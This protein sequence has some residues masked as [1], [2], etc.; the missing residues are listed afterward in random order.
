MIKKP[1]EYPKR[2]L[3]AVS[4]MSPQIISET[5]FALTQ[6]EE[7]FIPTEIRV[8]TTTTGKQKI[9]KGLFEDGYFAKLCADYQL[10]SIDFTADNIEVIQ[11]EDNTDLSD[12]KTV[13]ENEQAA[14]S[15]CQFVKKYTNDPDSAVH[16]SMA[17]GRKSMGFLMGYA[18]SLF[19]R[20]QDRLS[21][22][23]VTEQFESL[24]DFY[25]P[26]KDKTL[27]KDRLGNEHDASQA[28]VVLADIPFVRL[29]SGLPA[30]LI[31]R[32]KTDEQDKAFSYSN[33]V[34]SIQSV[35]EQEPHLTIDFTTKQVFVGHGKNSIE[36]KRLTDKEFGWLSWLVHNKKYIAD[37]SLTCGK[38]DTL[39]SQS[40]LNFV[41]Q[42]RI[43]PNPTHGNY[44][45]LHDSIKRGITQ[46]YISEINSRINKKMTER[47]GKKNAEPYLIAKVKQSSGTFD[48]GLTAAQ[49]T[50]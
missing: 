23:L 6:Q 4:G 47:L 25:Y 37:Y 2:I 42:H 12:I 8:I 20:P 40:F 11:N 45:K 10:P 28:K 7:A 14:N 33:I 46:D 18:I 9:V 32:V 3:L 17:G 49:I 15:I 34:R 38:G 36:I 26:P 27:L 19:G 1:H 41:L 24:P 44:G 39:D 22:V 29:S 31:S 5:L 35:V 21:H 48:I 30:N 16:V 50:I 43:Y 13:S